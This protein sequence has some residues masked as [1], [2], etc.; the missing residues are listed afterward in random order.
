MTSWSKTTEGD[1][2]SERE[3]KRGREG[4]RERRGEG[5]SG[6]TTPCK[7]TP[8]ILHGVA[9]PDRRKSY[10]EVGAFEDNDAMLQDHARVRHRHELHLRPFKKGI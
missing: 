6:D 7:V 10:L 3:I 1:R 9:S 5:G 8:V 2:Q 4:G